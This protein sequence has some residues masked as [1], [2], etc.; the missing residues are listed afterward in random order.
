MPKTVVFHIF[1]KIVNWNFLIFCTNSSLWSRKKWWFRFFVEKYKMT[2]F[3]PNWAKF[4]PNLGILVLKMFYFFP[5]FFYKNWKKLFWAKK[6]TFTIFTHFMT[7][8][9]PH[10]PK[11]AKK[12]LKL[13]FFTFFRRLRIGISLFFARSLVSGVEKM[14][15]SLFCRKFKD[16]PFCPKM[17][18]TLPIFGHFG[19]Q[20]FF[21]KIK[22]YILGKKIHF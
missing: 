9:S 21:T 13:R 8:L 10:L 7:S 6:F 3:G 15:V 18:Q 19:R 16:D 20:I 22:E 17:G 2:H 5:F 14:M 12:C 1:S 11:N 4:D